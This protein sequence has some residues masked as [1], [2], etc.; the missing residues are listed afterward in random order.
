MHEEMDVIQLHIVGFPYRKDIEGHVS[1]FLAEAPGHAMT[2][3]P[4][5]GNAHDKQAIRAFDWQGRFVG[6]VSQKDL[7]VAWGALRSSGSQS[8]RGMVVSTNIEH[9]CALFECVVRAYDGPITTLYP[10]K[11]FLD[12]QYSGPVLTLPDELD[13]LDYMMDEI[14]DRLAEQQEWDDERLHDFVILME[15]FANCSKYDI[16]AEMNDYRRRLII[17]LRDCHLEELDEVTEELEMSFGRTG[18][19]TMSGEVLDFWMQQMQSTE[20]IRQLMVHRRE[21]DAAA[22]EHELELFPE[23]MYFVWRENRDLFVSKIL[24]MHIPRES[25]WRFVSG[26]AFVEMARPAAMCIDIS[27][28][29]KMVDTVLPMDIDAMKEAELMLSRVNDKNGHAYDAELARLRNARDA[30]VASDVEPRRIGQVIARQNNFGGASG[31][32]GL[33]SHEAVRKLLE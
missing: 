33:I 23:S 15:R 12:W 28:V 2:L 8:L 29:T 20:T 1:E 17:K 13:N 21:Y 30:K 24:Y 11:P 27:A 10:Q 7:P 4:H 18:R 25:L 14:R 26:I 3:R 22:I 6:Y 5:P 16:S 31:M 9:P 32:E 19:E